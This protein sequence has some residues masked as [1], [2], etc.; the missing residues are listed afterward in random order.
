MPSKAI[1]RGKYRVYLKKGQDFYRAMQ[2]SLAEGNWN[3]VGLEAVHCAISA[4]D[5]LLAYAGGIRS[6]GQDHGDAARLL[7]ETIHSPDTV[8]NSAHLLRIIEMKN[9]VEYEA[10]DFT[11]EEAQDIAKHVERYLAWVRSFLPQ[12]ADSR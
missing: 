1:D 3:S 5:A 9:V 4:T 6:T 11:G 12:E 2:R 8:R 10:R 7:R